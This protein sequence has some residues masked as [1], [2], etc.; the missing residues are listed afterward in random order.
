MGHFFCGIFAK[1]EYILDVP[2]RLGGDY[3]R[4]LQSRVF[5]DTPKS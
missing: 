5:G 1:F 4:R 2:E 3:V